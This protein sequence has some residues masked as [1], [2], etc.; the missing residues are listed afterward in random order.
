MASIK[1]FIF[2]YL[3]IG[4]NKYVLEVFFMGSDKYH[5]HLDTFKTNVYSRKY[6]TWQHKIEET[7]MNNVTVQFMCLFTTCSVEG[8][9]GYQSPISQK[10][11]LH[12]EKVL[13]PK[14][15]HRSLLKA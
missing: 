4:E 6:Q 15:G 3:F 1:I 8:N 5:R 10:H 2:V 13:Q 9:A 12:P 7:H 14:G 11:L